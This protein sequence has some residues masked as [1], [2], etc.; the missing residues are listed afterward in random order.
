MTPAAPSPT[1]PVTLPQRRR[2]SLAEYH[3]LMEL[4]ILT[5]ADRVELIHGDLMQMVAKGT[6]HASCNTRLLRALIPL[7]GDRAIVRS[8]EPLSLSTPTPKGST[9]PNAESEPEPDCALV[10]PQADAYSTAHPTAE[11]VLLVIEIAQSSLEYDRTVKLALYAAA[12][13]PDYWL[14]NLPERRLETYADP[15]VTPQGT[16]T[17]SSRQTYPAP[18][19]VPLPGELALDLDLG[20][21]FPP[22]L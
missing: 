12:G 4:G 18:A 3:Q 13:L 10:R 19:I 21:V 8:Q 20:Q 6:A 5:E 11:A 14:F 17:Y 16:W 1:Q 22:A 9:V 2:C 15:Y 7:V